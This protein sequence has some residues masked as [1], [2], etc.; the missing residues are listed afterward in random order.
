[1]AEILKSLN[2]K[3]ERE[4]VFEWSDRKIYDF[5]ISTLNCIIEMNGSQHYKYAFNKTCNETQ[6]NDI[7]KYNLAIHNGINNYLIIDCRKSEY[8]YIFK[9]L[10]K[11]KILV[12]LG[13][14]NIDIEKCDRKARELNNLY[15]KIIE[16]WNQGKITTEISK[17]LGYSK[18]TIEKY[19][20]NAN[21]LGLVKYNGRH[22]QNKRTR[23]IVIDLETNIEYESIL[24]CSKAISRARTYIK[25]HKERFIIKE[26]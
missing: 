21:K 11:E 23:K 5:Y 7:Y 2:I 19:L 3:F 9:Q 12:N 22:D 1:M 13:I 4:K 25:S 15:K 14:K 8:D 26:E 24:D 10:C 6:S 20:K 16:L 18:N 17:E